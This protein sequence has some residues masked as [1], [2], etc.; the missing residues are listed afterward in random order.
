MSVES[1]IKLSDFAEF[2]D[3]LRGR[4]AQGERVVRHALRRAGDRQ[5]SEMRSDLDNVA[6]A[7]EKTL[8][9]LDRAA[10]ELRVQNDALVAATTDLEGTAA[11]FRDLFEL[12]P[13]AYLVTTTDTRILYAN[14]AACDLLGRRKNSLAGKP[15]ICYVP[16][17]DRSA[18]RAAVVRSNSGGTVTTWMATLLPT[19]GAG[20]AIVRIRIR[21]LFTPGARTGRALYWNITEE[22][23]EDLF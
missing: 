19:G 18:F 5:P 4:R 20:K 15:V 23:D 6:H 3:D 9:D 22:T 13:A 1:E 14:Q 11:L 16:L 12:A 2:A 8:G 21:A 7:L 10:E 17:E